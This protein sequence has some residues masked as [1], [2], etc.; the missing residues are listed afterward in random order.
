MICSHSLLVYYC[1]AHTYLILLNRQR[2]NKNLAPQPPSSAS[3]PHNIDHHTPITSFPPPSHNS[4]AYQSPS[5][6]PH[7]P[8]PLRGRS[9]V[10]ASSS[11]ILTAFLF[12]HARIP[13]ALVCW[14]IGQQA[15]NSC[16]ILLLDAMETGS[17]ERID[18]VEKAYIVFLQLQRNGVHGLAGM[19]VDKIS[20]GLA[21]LGR[22]RNSRICGGE[23]RG[24]DIRKT[25][26]S[27]QHGHPKTA[28]TDVQISNRFHP[29]KD[30]RLVLAG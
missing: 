2:I 30:G 23:R 6:S 15:F 25:A 28:Q 19:A 20:W 8:I 5:L 24:E 27:W 7:Q 17:L 3:T 14:N 22:M 9:L 18:K 26:K 13:A 10:L 4:H 1:K 16:M 29:E 12:F 21:R 11:D